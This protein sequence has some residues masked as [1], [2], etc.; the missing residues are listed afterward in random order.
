MFILYPPLGNSPKTFQFLIIK[1]C[2][3]YFISTLLRGINF[4]YEIFSW[5]IFTN[6]LTNVIVILNLYLERGFQ[7]LK[8][9][10]MKR[11]AEQ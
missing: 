4:Y 7:K 5:L 10:K 2:L 1:Y 11:E 8:A 3:Q 6:L 9:E